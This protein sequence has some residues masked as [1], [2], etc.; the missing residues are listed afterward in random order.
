MV[1]QSLDVNEGGDIASNVA[2]ASQVFSEYGDFI[3]AVI[4]YKI[5]DPDQADDIFQDF[6]LSLVSKPLPPN[7]RNVKSY[8]Y[9]AIINDTFDAV[10]RVERYRRQLKYLTKFSNRAINKNGP[11][12]ALIESEERAKMFRL[13]ESLLPGSEAEAVVLRLRSEKDIGEIA[14]R[15]NISKRSVSRYLC[16]GLKKIRKFLLEKRGV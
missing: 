2:R 13:I 14:G 5:G 8:I 15:M 12:N 3:H 6:F 10:R 9:R 11:E 7:V 1:V 16:V 4:R